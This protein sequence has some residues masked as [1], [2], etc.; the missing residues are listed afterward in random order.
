V[1]DRR[2]DERPHLPYPE[3]IGL[4][5]HTVTNSSKTAPRLLAGNDG[6]AVESGQLGCT[7]RPRTSGS[8]T[9]STMSTST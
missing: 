3:I 1:K 7:P 5:E 6:R 8:Y 9:S 2:R 4:L